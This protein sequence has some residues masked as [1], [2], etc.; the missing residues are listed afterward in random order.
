MEH[1]SSS[2]TTICT[3]YHVPLTV[4]MAAREWLEMVARSLQ[5]PQIGARDHLEFR[6][7]TER[8]WSTA[9][10][11]LS[12]NNPLFVFR[13]GCRQGLGGIAGHGYADSVAALR[14][15][16][17]RGHPLLQPPAV[18]TQADVD[19]MVSFILKRGFN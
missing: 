7:L 10:D 5:N 19:G 12:E 16:V 3:T 13:E 1:A 14:G 11:T 2:A 17:S 18:Y 15:L 9:M 8:E 4:S 6:A